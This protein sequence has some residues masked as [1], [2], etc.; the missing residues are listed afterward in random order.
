LVG[1]TASFGAAVSARI[2]ESAERLRE[3]GSVVPYAHANVPRDPEATKQRLFDAAVAEFAS[4]GIAGARID[5]IARRAGANKQLIYAYFGSKQE[6]FD[7]VVTDQVARF[8]HDVQLDPDDVPAFAGATFDFFTDNPAIV[9]LGAWHSLEPPQADKPIAAIKRSIDQR[10][11]ALRRAQAAGTV[12]ATIP[13]DQLLVMIYAIAR[14][15][16]ATVPELHAQGSKDRARRAARRRTVVE[17]VRRL[18]TPTEQTS[19]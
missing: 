14:A 17:A 5:R 11:R 6:L 18:V 7:R 3:T 12:D 19:T 8:H 16:V 9:R 2:G 15:W 4:H 1:H 13:S 10:V